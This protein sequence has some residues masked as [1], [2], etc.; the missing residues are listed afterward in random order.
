MNKTLMERER[1]MI[2]GFRLGQ[3]FWA[4]AVDI[5]C[6]MVN[7]S[8]SS[9]LDDMTPHE[10]WTSKKPSLTHLTVFG[11]DDYV[12][13]RKE[14]MSKLDKNDEKCIYIG[15]KDGLKGYKIWNLETKKVVYS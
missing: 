2:S 10:V 14:N 8:P 11:F 12:H 15:Y 4:E 5:A 7:R 6:H 9:T 1:S 3:E 13:V